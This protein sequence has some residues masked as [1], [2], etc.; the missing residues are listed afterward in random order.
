MKKRTSRLILL[1]LSFL[2]FGVPAFSQSSSLSGVKA[3]LDLM[4]AGLDKTKIPTGFLWDTSAN[5]VEREDYNGTALTDS[6][7]VSMDVMRD[8]LYSIN[9]ASVGADTIGVQ[10][11]ISRL[12]RYSSSTSQK[13]GILF[14]PYNYIVQNALTDN[15][16]VYSNDRV[17]DS[18]IGGVWQNPYSDDV[19]FAYAVGK[20]TG[21][22]T[23]TS[24]SFTNV[25]SLSTRSF[26]SILFDPGDG[27]GYRSVTYNNVLWVN[28][29]EEGYH[30][31]KLKVSY[32]GN[33]YV[34]H[35]YI[36]VYDSS[37]H[38]NTS[39]APLDM[40]KRSFCA[41]YAGQIYRA[42]VTYKTPLCFDNPLIVA[43]GFD[44]WKLGLS[45]S[46]S[47]DDYSGF[48]SYSTI[49]E[50]PSLSSYDLF[51]VDWCDCG[52]D[53][54]AN[55]EVLKA[56]IRWVNENKSSGHRNVV[57]GQ[58]MGG[59]ISRYAL[60]HMELDH[61]PHDTKLFISHDVPY[62]GANVSPGLMF[63][64]WDLF[65]ICDNTVGFILASLFGQRPLYDELGRIGSYTSVRQ[66]LPY[67]VDSLWHY[68]SSLFNIMQN[69]FTVMGFPLGD[70]GY[71]IDNVAIINGGRPG[72]GAL[73]FY[74]MGERL[75]DLNLTISSDA[76]LGLIL[77]CAYAGGARYSWIPGR[78][79][80]NYDLEAFPFTS[81]GALVHKMTITYKKKFL[82]LLSRS[83][84]IK[85]VQ[86]FSPSSG[87]AFDNVS[88]SSFFMDS[89]EK[90]KDALDS[91]ITTFLPNQTYSF[92]VT[93]RLCFVPTAS[94]MAMPNAFDRDFYNNKP[95]P[96]VD[97]PFSAYVLQQNSSGHIDF[98]AGISSWLHKIVD[99]DIYGPLIAFPGDA[100]S[101][102]TSPYASSFAFS[103]DGPDNLSISSTGGVLSGN[104]TGLATVYAKDNAA[105]YAITKK[106]DIL[107]GLPEMV[108][109]YE[110]GGNDVYTVTAEYLYEE[111]QEFIEDH[112]LEDSLFFYWKLTVDGVPKDSVVVHTRLYSFSFDYNE[113]NAVIEFHVASRGHIGPTSSLNVNKQYP[114]TQ[115]VIAANL[116]RPGMVIYVSILGFPSPPYLSFKRNEIISYTGSDPTHIVVLGKSFP[117]YIEYLG[118]DTFYKY[119]LFNDTDV[120]SYATSVTPATSPLLLDIAL[121][122]S[123]TLIQT[124]TIPIFYGWP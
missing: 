98:F 50:E 17:S 14:Q 27:G 68:D 20:E 3:Q 6:N 79:T 44:P 52:A 4:F 23:T 57:L 101:L 65:D 115:N 66:M 120:D 62:L 118:D 83:Y 25:D 31:T 60:R 35:A 16:I 54:R 84:T 18:Y 32:G 64:F 78:T 12:Q 81:N 99:V 30:E 61:E 29:A 24:F 88:S 85:D 102:T 26:Q 45:D 13:V 15:L 86:H 90:I 94:A 38:Q 2:S 37:L 91:L 19:L 47:D 111:K 80:I 103:V 5:L 121:W 89:V 33:E 106:K 67:Y 82:W 109:S 75:L 43:E 104:G 41:E 63:A 22:S 7:Y 1:L 95:E 71:T 58:S 55:A 92:D 122:S 93:H 110:V 119:P 116:K 11:A 76:F 77:S 42:K 105:G 34:S 48:T 112:N 72:G 70:E 113:T 97:T 40:A 108:L 100:F 53:I 56:V 87:Q 114:Y 96:L 74:S 59:L 73:S 28:Y 8:L 36:Y 51:Y 124:T 10:A 107:V 21:I 69:T 9:S 123:G 49:H 117:L 46:N 39:S